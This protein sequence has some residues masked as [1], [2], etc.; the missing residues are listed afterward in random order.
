M[1]TDNSTPIRPAAAIAQRPELQPFHNDR[2]TDEQISKRLDKQYHRIFQ[3]QNIVQT[4]MGVI[5]AREERESKP[6]SL[7]DGE[8]TALWGSLSV[9]TETLEDIAEQLE[10]PAILK[11][12]DIAGACAPG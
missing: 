7:G 4:V 12:Q 6:D 8:L 9:V 10:P 1:N 3:M 2:A 11:R 5:A